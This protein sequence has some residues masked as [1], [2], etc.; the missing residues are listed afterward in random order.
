MNRKVK[1]VVIGLITAMV[2]GLGYGAYLLLSE[3]KVDGTRVCYSDQKG[4]FLLEEDIKISIQVQSE[5]MGQ[6]LISTWNALHPDHSG[7]VTYEVVDEPTPA[8]AMM[9]DFPT[10]V[11]YTSQKDAVYYNDKLLRFGGQFSNVI[12]TMIPSQFED[13]INLNH[14]IFMPYTV[15]GALFAYNQPLGE[16]M[17]LEMQG[18]DLPEVLQSFESIAEYEPELLKKVSLTYPLSFIDYYSYYPLLTGGRWNLNFSHHPNKPEFDSSEFLEGLELTEL[19]KSLQIDA[20][21]KAPIPSKSLKWRN[22]TALIKDETLMSFVY[23]KKHFDKYKE[24][25]VYTPFPT[26][27]GNHLS[28][29]A[30]VNGYIAKGDTKNPSA[31]A[32]VLRIMRTP[33]LLNLFPSEL[34][35]TIIMHKDGI[36][37]LSRDDLD[38]VYAYNY[39]HPEPLTT[40]EGTDILSRSIWLDVDFMDILANLYDGKIDKVEAQKQFVERA[41]AWLKENEAKQHVE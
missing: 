25:I 28:P 39:H 3:C 37:L 36:E 30:E 22:E 41:N 12:S 16:K 14:Y 20:T 7:Q 6:A 2:L 4:Q 19:F 27:K 10:D 34:E 5:A 9:T 35:E 1:W 32:E 24:G 18:Q 15:N 31:I 33:D 26:F 23:D 40:L 8:K 13:N 17:K 11:V 29:I 38:K 21:K